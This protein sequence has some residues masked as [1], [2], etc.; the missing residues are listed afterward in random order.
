MRRDWWDNW[1]PCTYRLFMRLPW[2]P[3]AKMRPTALQLWQLRQRR[4]VRA[5]DKPRLMRMRVGV[6]P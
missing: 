6:R 2:Q 4:L 5:L 3:V 1:Y